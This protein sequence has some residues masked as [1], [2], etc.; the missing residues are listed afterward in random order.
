MIK[1]TKEESECLSQA[2]LLLALQ[3]FPRWDESFIPQ[4]SSIPREFCGAS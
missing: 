4:L 2:K 3:V 1:C